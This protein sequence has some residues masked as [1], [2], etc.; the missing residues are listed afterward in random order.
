[1][2]AAIQHQ[3]PEENCGGGEDYY[4]DEEEEEEEEY[5]DEYVEESEYFEEHE[6]I[7]EVVDE[8]VAD[9]DEEYVEEEEYYEEEEEEEEE[10]EQ[11]QGGGL[12]AMIAA[13]ASKRQDRID[14]G[15]Y[16]IT[17]QA[18]PNNDYQ[19]KEEDDDDA[20]PGGMS[21]MIAAAANKRKDRLDQGGEKKVT[22]VEKPANAGMDMVAMIAQKANARNERIEAGGELKVRV[23]PKAHKNVFVDVAL[24]AA[25]VG[26]LTRLNEHT[27]E[28]VAVGKEEEVW[29]GPSG[30]RTD[31]LRSTFFMAINE[32]AALGALKRQKAHEVTNYDQNAYI[33][34]EE[35]EDIDKMTDEQGRRVVRQMYL[36]DRRIDEE[37]KYKKE[38]WSAENAAN[39]IQYNSMDEVALPSASA[40]KWRPKTTQKTHRELMDA[41]SNGVAERAWE[42]NYRLNRPKANLMLTRKC[43][44]KFCVNPNPYQTHK[45]KQMEE[46]GIEKS[47]GPILEVKEDERKKTTQAWNSHVKQTRNVKPGDW[48]ESSSYTPV[49]NA[50]PKFKV[51]RPPPKPVKDA[52]PEPARVAPQPVEMEPEDDGDEPGITILL[53]ETTTWGHKREK[54]AKPKKEKPKKTKK[55]SKK[56]KDEDGGCSIM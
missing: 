45:Y 2:S 47:D 44:C 12:A 23:I 14:Q 52:G 19:D 54:T 42:R 41:I 7:E 53:D 9:D 49:P 35:P 34:E 15:D 16:Q 4:D 50:V 13:A 48:S 38:E 11:P 1:M 18:A 17:E 37:R 5:I 8:V 28:A 31:H 46:E 30:L 6:Y 27:V 51:S 10:E 24:E 55:K 36:I 56:K 21:A 22:H 20:E 32:A 43:K 25:R 29:G 40:P 26:T 33:E 39:I 3:G